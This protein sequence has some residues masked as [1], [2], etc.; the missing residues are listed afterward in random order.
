MDV[1]VSNFVLPSYNFRHDDLFLYKHA[2]QKYGGRIDLFLGFIMNKGI[3][4]IPTTMK[5]LPLLPQN[6]PSVYHLPIPLVITSP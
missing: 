1:S 6:V 4:G 5:N 3:S 2:S